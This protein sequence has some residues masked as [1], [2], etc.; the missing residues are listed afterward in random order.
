MK[1]G[2]KKLPALFP[3]LGNMSTTLKL[4]SSWPAH[5]SQFCANTKANTVFCLETSWVSI[6]EMEEIKK[7]WKK[8]RCRVAE[9]MNSLT[10]LWYGGLCCKIFRQWSTIHAI[11]FALQLPV[12]CFILICGKEKITYT[13]TPFWCKKDSH[14]KGRI[15]TV[16]GKS[17]DIVSLCV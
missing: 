7:D 9:F 6:K 11:T 1:Q 8:K 3:I 13:C 2:H 16:R 14:K 5:P 10:L 15:H 12:R 17:I 4:S